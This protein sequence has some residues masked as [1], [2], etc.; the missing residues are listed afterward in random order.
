MQMI[1]DVVNACF[2]WLTMISHYEMRISDDRMIHVIMVLSNC[3][4]F[5]GAAL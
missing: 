5:V 2:D 1:V 4:V 3:R